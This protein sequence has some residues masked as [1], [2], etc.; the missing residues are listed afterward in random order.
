MFNPLIGS[1]NDIS[2]EDLVKKINE[3]H[4]KRL[5]A[6]SWGKYELA[7]HILSTLNVYQEEYKKRMAE[8]AE[9]QKDSKYFKDK[10]SIKK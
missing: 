4:T 3:L 6:N 9:K 7:N 1:L 5:Q 8:E 10:V 2:L